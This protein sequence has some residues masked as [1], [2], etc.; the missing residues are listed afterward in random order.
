MIEKGYYTKKPIDRS[1]GFVVQ[2]GDN[3]PSG[4]VHGYIPD[5][6]TEERK[7]PLEISL[8]VC[9]YLRDLYILYI[10]FKGDNLVHKRFVYSVYSLFI[11]VLIW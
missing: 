11:Y 5:G 8:R 4:T 6:A 3:D 10:F 9:N 7:V 2:M 1:D